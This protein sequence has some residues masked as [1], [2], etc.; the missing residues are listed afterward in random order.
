MAIA[1][2]L[3]AVIAVFRGRASDLLPAFFLTP[4][5][6]AVVQVVG[7]GGFALS[8]LYLATTGRLERFQS[9]LADRELDPPSPE[10]PAFE[11]WLEEL[12]PVFEVLLP[13][14]VVGLLA[15]TA[16][17][18]VVLFVALY[19]VALAA[20]LSASVAT[21]R[22]RR[23]T[24]AALAGARR[25][26]GAMVVL[27]VF[28][29][30]LWVLATAVAG[31]AGAMAALLLPGILFVAVALVVTLAWLAAVVCIRALFAFA[32][33]AVVEDG[34]GA[35]D[36]LRRAGGYIRRNAG[37]AVGY[38]LLALGLLG[39]VGV[40]SGG[41][42]AGARAAA[43]A[44]FVVVSPA[45]AVLKTALYAGT[46]DAIAPPA[47]PERSAAAQLS[48]GL[49]RGLAELGAFVRATPG[50]HAVATGLILGGFGLG[51]MLAAPYEGLVTASIEARLEDHFAP[52]A[53]VFFAANNWTVAV[54][55]ALSGLT[56][57]VPAAASLVFNGVVFGV[58]GRLEADPEALAAFVAPHGVLEIPAIIAAGA[59]GLWLG[60]AGWRRLRGRCSDAE[61]ADRIER[62]FWVLVGIGVVLAVAG[63]IEGFISPSVA[64]LV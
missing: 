25:H 11:A 51:W 28:E 55:T 19:G 48:S 13:P 14:A 4:A 62:S 39:V 57:A 29:V 35:G 22:D 31:V 38:Y 5:I 45:L 23:G 20:Q 63:F 27:V 15:V 49:R 60:V 50:T 43:V 2:A 64:G 1:P 58:Y 16:L 12:V 24:T 44:G 26:T 53:A 3:R 6:S 59:A 33:V 7:L 54:G 17:V 21:L 41:G 36:G 34:V 40:L 8:Y 30:F 32:P 47:V 9:A 10:D 52:T 61:L 56:L 46:V 37:D 42:E 18:A